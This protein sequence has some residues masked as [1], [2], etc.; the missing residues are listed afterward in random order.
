LIQ[1]SSLF[2]THLVKKLILKQ[3]Y[4]STTKT[5]ISEEDLLAFFTQRPLREIRF[6][7]NRYSAFSSTK[8]TISL[9]YVHISLKIKGYTYTTYVYICKFQ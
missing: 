6:V 9:F 1:F 5:S 2:V 7:G 8:V 3:A 4:N